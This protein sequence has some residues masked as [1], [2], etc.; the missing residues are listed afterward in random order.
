MLLTASQVVG[1]GAYAQ[2]QNYKFTKI[3]EVKTTS[4]KNQNRSGTCWSFAGISFL[5]AEL[6]RQGKGEYD[7]SEMFIVRY[8]YLKKALNFVRLHGHTVFGSGGQAHDVTN[9][10]R[11]YGIVPN[12]N[13]EGLNYGESNHVHGE[14]NAVFKAI[15]KAVVEN[16]NKKL[17]TAWLE[18]F[19]STLDAYLGEVPDNFEHKGKNFSPKTF[20]T[21]QLGLNMDDYIE[22]TSYTH[23]PFYD[24][25]ILEVP[26]NWSND[27]Y[28]NVPLEDLM[29]IFDYSIE[30]GF[31]LC[32]DGDVDED[33]SRINGYARLSEDSDEVTQKDRQR[34]FDNY[35]T[36]DDHLMHITGIAKDQS[37]TKYYITK[38]SWSDKNTYNGYWYMSESYVRQHTIAIMIHKD[39][40]PTDIAK[41]LKLK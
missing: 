8:A 16:K 28:Y 29:A 30:N 19:K 11:E 9:V 17:S 21:D 22:L 37:G 1:M 39:A 24:K 40:V 12:K 27:S 6:I 20:T 18:S 34:T 38:N 3:K 15:V 33:F 41:K 23:H 26:D 36:T 4:V 7:L 2:I 25:F 14:M 13:Y 35:I 31:S 32:W 10:I 5:E